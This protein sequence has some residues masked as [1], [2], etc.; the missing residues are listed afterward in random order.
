MNDLE[1]FKN[2]EK[3]LEID[4]DFA[5][6]EYDIGDFLKVV[7]GKKTAEVSLYEDY[8]KNGEPLPALGDY[9]VISSGDLKCIIKNISVRIIEYKDINSKVLE[10][11][12]VFKEEFKESYESDFK[13]TLKEYSLTLTPETL[14]V[15]E[16][17]KVEDIKK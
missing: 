15:L 16:E 12:C 5:S 11:L 8:I 13:D 1:Y 2:Y 7:D 6:Y 3:G 10:K 4:V 17:F 14:I 9:A